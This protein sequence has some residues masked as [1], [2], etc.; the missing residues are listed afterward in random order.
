MIKHEDFKTICKRDDYVDISMDIKNIVER[1][2]WN[3]V[4]APAGYGKT[5]ILSMLYYYLDIDEDS[6]ELFSG[7]ELSINYADY[8]THLNK[9]IVLPLD[10]SDFSATSMEG[11]KEQIYAKILELYQRKAHFLWDKDRY[12]EDYL[13]ILEGNLAQYVERRI[14]FSDEVYKVSILERSLLI[15]MDCMHSLCDS[16]DHIDNRKIVLLLNDLVNL[17]KYANEYGYSDEMENFLR[18]FLDFEP[19]KKCF[20]YLQ[21]GDEELTRNKYGYDGDYAW[22]GRH[23]D[24]QCYYPSY[25]PPSDRF[26]WRDQEH[27]IRFSE[28]GACNDT[29]VSII[30]VQ[31]EISPVNLKELILTGRVQIEKNK[32]IYLESVI[33]EKKDVNDKY[34][35]PLSNDV[36]K[37]SPNLGRR[38]MKTLIRNE[39]YNEINDYLKKLYASSRDFKDY[40]DLYELVQNISRDKKMDWTPDARNELLEKCNG[41]RDG[42]DISIHS[43]DQYW[44]YIDISKDGHSRFGTSS[45]K[46]YVSLKEEKVKDVYIGAIEEL[47]RNGNN[48][49]VSK[50][51]KLSRGENICFWLKKNEFY[52]LEK[53][54]KQHDDILINGNPFVAHRGKLGISHD[55]MD[56]NSHN[57]QQAMIIWDYFQEIE[58]ASQIELENM[59]RLYVYGWNGILT[60]EHPFRQDFMRSRAQTFVIIMDTLD[61]LLGY[62]Q[63]TDDTLLL[64][65]SNDIWGI[66]DSALC[67][68]DVNKKYARYYNKKSD[69][70]F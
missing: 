1:N 20:I 40:E 2:R 55:L 68:E 31:T 28:E 11:A 46:V 69:I 36:P 42:W 63:I 25:L 12:N 54:M 53:Y 10:F 24:Y 19:D 33:Q 7:S 6:E 70:I 62:T 17:E 18:H 29:P 34:R 60:D 51:S 41:I 48:G 49:F 47:I 38:E 30:A 57:A 39:R 5:T 14:L 13:D 65:D 66:L 44:D 50:V 52:I 15:I 27:F 21:V 58:D 43:S 26:Y 3:V 67:W 4:A 9:Y 32:R 45:I 64:S 23:R 35:I 8:Q 37:F 16:Y 59:Y 22:Y 56:I 61:V